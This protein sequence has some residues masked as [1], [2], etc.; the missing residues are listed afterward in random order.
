MLI[1]FERCFHKQISSFSDDVFSKYQCGF[2][3]GHSAQECLVVLIEI[4]KSNV[5]QGKLFC[6]L[7]TDLAMA[8]DCLPLDLFFAKLHTYGFDNKSLALSDYL[9]NQ[10]QRTKG[11]Q[12]FSTWLEILSGVPQGSILIHCPAFFQYSP[13]WPICYHEWYWYKKFRRWQYNLHVSWRH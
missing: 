2:R 12:E 5:H 13:L 11:G 3:K 7:M 10:I 1:F 9:S 6:E 4:W 8:L